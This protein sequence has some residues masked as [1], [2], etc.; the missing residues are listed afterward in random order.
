MAL[1]EH[2]THDIQATGGGVTIITITGGGT[3]QSLGT[4]LVPPR[5]ASIVIR[6]ISGFLT[7]ANLPS[8]TARA[9]QIFL[10]AYASGQLTQVPSR[11][12]DLTAIWMHGMSHQVVGS[13][14]NTFSDHRGIPI[15][16][17]FAGRPT[18]EVTIRNRAGTGT[19]PAFRLFMAAASNDFLVYL[20][21]Q[22]QFD[23]IW[24][25]SYKPSPAIDLQ[26]FYANKVP[27]LA[28]I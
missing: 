8:A 18:R 14:V 22:I 23:L 17:D 10:A 9:C 28:V 11:T 7:S 27:A 3:I 4:P 2:L 13:P 25:R 26:E 15:D 24:D 20:R 1:V 21:L 5:G 12:Q 6:R 16:V 19:Q